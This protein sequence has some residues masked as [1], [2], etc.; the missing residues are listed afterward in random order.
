MMARLAFLAGLALGLATPAQAQLSTSGGPISYSADHLEY[1]DGQ[2]RLVL[3]GDVDIVQNDARLRAASVT[4]YFTGS[5]SGGLASGD[6]QRMVAEGDVYYVR[7][8]Q[9]ARGDRAVYET[10]TDTVTFTGNV[11]MAGDGSVVRG[12]SMV[13]HMDSGA[14]TLRPAAGRRVSGVFRP[15]AE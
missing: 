15:E 7:P 3:S 4:L 5:G 10:A 13:L 2:R 6:I 12:E 14:A 11:V 9:Q 8:T 1:V